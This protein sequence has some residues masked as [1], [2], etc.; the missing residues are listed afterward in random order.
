MRLKTI[1]IQMLWFKL[2]VDLLSKAWRSNRIVESAIFCCT[3]PDT[4]LGDVAE[5]LD[6]T[7]LLF[8]YLIKFY[9]AWDEL[10][11]GFLGNFVYFRKF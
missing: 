10:R 9:W 4:L 1:K 11:H 2:L 7:Y 6:F 3:D 8:L 5:L